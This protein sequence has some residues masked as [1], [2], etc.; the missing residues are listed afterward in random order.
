[1]NERQGEMRQSVCLFGILNV[2][3]CKKK[4][5]PTVIKEFSNDGQRQVANCLRLTR[6]GLL[7]SFTSAIATRPQV[8]GRYPFQLHCNSECCT[9]TICR[10]QMSLS[11]PLQFRML[12]G[13]DAPAL[14]SVGPKK[15]NR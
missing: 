10:W 14:E 8:G 15:Q 11:P 1:M 2:S 12:N 9:E 5:T 13:M 7:Y 3:L 6:Q 4:K